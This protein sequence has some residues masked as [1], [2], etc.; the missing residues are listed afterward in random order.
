MHKCGDLNKAFT[1]ITGCAAA[2][3]GGAR[4]VHRLNDQ[5]VE[6][7]LVL[8]PLDDILVHARTRDKSRC[9]MV[10]FG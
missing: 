9:K 8:G 6:Y 10:M 4:S 5:V 3:N 7:H 2:D 1:C